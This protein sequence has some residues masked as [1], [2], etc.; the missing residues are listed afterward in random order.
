MYDIYLVHILYIVP[1]I[2]NL[3]KF[4]LFFHCIIFCTS[5]LLNVYGTLII[6]K[7]YKNYIRKYAELHSIHGLRHIFVIGCVGSTPTVK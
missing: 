3:L 2:I 7:K 6:Y 4:N 5:T 1:I